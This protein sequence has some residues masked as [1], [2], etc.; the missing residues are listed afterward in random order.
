MDDIKV[1]TIPDIVF[2]QSKKILLI[3]P[4]NN[5]KDQLQEYI[6]S[7]DGPVSVYYYMHNDKNLKWLFSVL[8]L[9]DISIID[10]DNCDQHLNHFLGYVL[11]KPY[12]YYKAD[13][14]ASPWDLVN[15][16]RFFDVNEIRKI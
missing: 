11:S 12:T 3:Q 1:V 10:I 13:N 4:S 9:V 15:K 2:D 16:N 6:L 5:L 7:I 8:E 14:I